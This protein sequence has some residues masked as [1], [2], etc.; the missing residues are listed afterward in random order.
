[1]TD[2]KGVIYLFFLNRLKKVSIILAQLFILRL[3]VPA[4]E[5]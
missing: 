5:I 1:M 3:Q 4:K 2:Y